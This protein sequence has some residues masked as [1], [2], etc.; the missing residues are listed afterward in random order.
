MEINNRN[1]ERGDALYPIMIE[2]L[3]KDLVIDSMKRF[4]K[5]QENGKIQ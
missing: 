3:Y 5:V 1:V 2:L 4:E